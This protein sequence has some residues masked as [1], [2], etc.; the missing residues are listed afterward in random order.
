MTEIGRRLHAYSAEDR[1]YV[2]G[3]LPRNLAEAGESNQLL[4]LLFDFDFLL[5]KVRALGMGALDADL[6]RAIPVVP[7]EHRRAVE[8]V[9]RAV[10]SGAAPVT[11]D[12][13]QLASQLVGRLDVTA[14]DLVENLVRAAT[15]WD[16]Q[17]W[18]CTVAPTLESGLATLLRVFVHP[19]GTV[20]VATLSADGRVV[21]LG[22]DLGTVSIWR[23][24][25]PDPPA[26]WHGSG[27]VTAAALSTDGELAVWA[28]GHAI[29]RWSPRDEAA[30]SVLADQVGGFVATALD[31]PT[32]NVLLAHTN[33]SVVSFHLATGDY[34]VYR[35][36]ESP[37]LG[38][39]ADG[40]HAILLSLRSARDPDL[41]PIQ[42][43][44][45]PARVQLAPTE[46][47]QFSIWHIHDDDQ[48]TCAFGADT[49]G[50]LLD[51]TGV[52]RLWATTRQGART[53]DFNAIL[54][55]EHGVPTTDPTTCLA[56]SHSG[57]WA[58]AGRA[59]GALRTVRVFKDPQVVTRA[60]QGS[61]PVA[62]AISDDGRRALA[63]SRNGAVAL[64]DLAE[65]RDERA[66]AWGAAAVTADARVLVGSSDE[67]GFWI[68]DERH[69][70][71][72]RQL[73]DAQVTSVALARDGGRVA[74]TS[75]LYGLRL[76]DLDRQ[77]DEPR[78]VPL[79]LG[80]AVAFSP[81]GGLVVAG[82]LDSGLYVC[83]FASGSETGRQSRLTGGS[84]RS[85]SRPPA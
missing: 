21:L 23:V 55:G 42:S 12:P 61:W 46:K 39:A 13:G 2:L 79:S 56:L 47:N 40:R 68:R 57:E 36:E 52:S 30:P 25:D 75:M 66:V 82:S 53:W 78:A 43:A 76:L 44:S 33:G 81:G 83:D 15:A 22:C 71:S 60:H 24:D 62:V 37:V 84:S 73:Q 28:D 64:W 77:E 19:G 35:E 6:E 4:T 59:G 17:P 31:D 32:A 26:V 63:A 51:I 11:R 72:P 65:Q 10:R 34:D 16:E 85:L 14:S 3:E 80:S 41:I 45:E 48:R 8:T 9:R 70:G 58:I 50:A 54:S 38:I 18:L 74:W 49:P 27:A 7:E 1:R 20:G 67:S 69:P 5:A 29:R